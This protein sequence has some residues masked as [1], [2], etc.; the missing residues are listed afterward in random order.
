[1]SGAVS[2]S[3]QKLAL[4]PG[5]NVYFNT[6]AHDDLPS[7]AIQTLVVPSRSVTP[8]FVYDMVNNRTTTVVTS[9]YEYST[10]PTMA[11]AITG[12]G[13]YVAFAQGTT[14]YFRKKATASAFKSEIQVLQGNYQAPESPAYSIDFQNERTT[15]TIVATDEY[16]TNMTSWTSGTGAILPVTPGQDVYIRVKAQG[17]YPASDTQ[18]LYVPARPSTPA[19]TI[20]YLWEETI[21]EFT[22]AYE[23]AYN[24]GM[25]SAITG[26][27]QYL[28]LNPGSVVYIRRKATANSFAS[29]IQ[30]LNVPVRPAAPTFAI[31][32]VN[33]TTETAVSSDYQFAD[34]SVLAWAD[35]GNG[36]VVKL[37]PGTPMYFRKKYTTSSFASDIQT[38]NVPSRPSAPSFTI[39]YVLEKTAET[40]SSEYEY[41]L[42][43]DMTGAIRG[44]GS[45][46]TIAPGTSNYFRK[47]ATASAFS[48]NIQTINAPARPATPDYTI[49]YALART[50]EVIV[51]SDE[52]ANNS[53]MTGAA[54]GTGA[55]A[56]LI[57][58]TDMYFRTK[59]TTS[60]FCSA[61]QFMNVDSRPSAPLFTIDYGASTTNEIISDQFEI[62]EQNNFNTLT[63]GTGAKLTL[64]PGKD[65]YFRQIASDHSFSSST[66]LLDVPDRNTLE[67]FGSD[68]V[69][70]NFFVV[71]ASIPDGSAFSLDDLMISNGTAQNLR[72]GNVFDVYATTKGTVVVS[73]PANSVSANSF[74]SNVIRVY[75]D[76]SITGIPQIEEDKFNV[77]P[78][79]VINGNVNIL[80]ET[81]LNYS[82]DVISASGTLVKSFGKFEGRYQLLDVSDLPKGMY[83]LKISSSKGI[84]LKKVM[85]E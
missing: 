57:P 30:T 42:A 45:K 1:M 18:H 58:G 70:V 2:G 10:S 83:V 77:Y 16:S 38:L 64:I 46:V 85:I 23:Y 65:L 62:S 13:N 29:Q 59:A 6:R 63:R 78:N 56:A 67:Y 37:I 5:N 43:S 9:E 41:A 34:N 48:S 26:A 19:F 22:S 71:R 51:A 12:T 35:T 50:N 68:T 11:G 61:I 54:S 27:G 53:N 25:I 40:L 33:E 81:A 14:M 72:A 74:A 3:G 28:D 52:F 21:E 8:T 76:N 20:D 15:S 31:N 36:Q 80:T 60:A 7:S 44:S 39:D 75:Y 66:F 4:T 69:T 79:P 82:V 24:S 49:N 32:Y 55:T 84:S 17:Y 47:A 73:I